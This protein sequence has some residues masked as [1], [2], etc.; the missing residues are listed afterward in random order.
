MSDLAV[1]L[2]DARVATGKD[3]DRLAAYH[4]AVALFDAHWDTDPFDAD[5]KDLTAPSGLDDGAKLTLAIHG[6]AQLAAQAAVEQGVAA[7][8]LT[9]LQLLALL[10]QDVAAPGEV[11]DGE[12]GALRLGTCADGLFL[13]ARSAP[14]RCAGISAARSR[15]SRGRRPTAPAWGAT[16]C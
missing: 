7:G 13:C 2:A 9:Q 16:I 15:P 8:S 12:G 5:V 3:P 1:A 6:L 4:T 14:T 10:R 11:F